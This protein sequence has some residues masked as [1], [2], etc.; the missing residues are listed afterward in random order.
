MAISLSSRVLLSSAMDESE[1]FS[2]EGK[3]L[4]G[5]FGGVWDVLML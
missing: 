3:V 5:L 1:R 2:K 4:V